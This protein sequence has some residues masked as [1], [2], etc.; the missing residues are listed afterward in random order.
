MV[1]W[2][3]VCKDFKN[4]RKKLEKFH[5]QILSH[6]NRFDGEFLCH[7]LLT[8]LSFLCLDWGKIFVKNYNIQG[9]RICIEPEY[10]SG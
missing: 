8:I 9:Y 2:K 6:E 3:C 5:N 1:Y 10:I 7:Y 4:A